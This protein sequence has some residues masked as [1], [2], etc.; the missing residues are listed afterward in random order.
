MIFTY[1]DYDAVKLYFKTITRKKIFTNGCFDLFHYGH[2]ELLKRCK[3][4][5][6]DCLIIGL[7]SDKSVRLLKGSKRPIISEIQRAEI[8][9]SLLCVDYVIIFDEPTPSKI[10]NMI[11]PDIIIKGADWSM[12]D[13]KN[14]YISDKVKYKLLPL[15]PNISTTDIINRILNKE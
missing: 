2:L 11:N 14:M 3:D 5:P 13:L 6:S 7:N 10:L 9:Q 4:H 15:I 1:N 8:L 12:D